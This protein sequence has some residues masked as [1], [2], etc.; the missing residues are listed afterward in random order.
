MRS[1]RKEIQKLLWFFIVYLIKNKAITKTK[2]K[3]I[4]N[5]L[6]NFI[7]KLLIE[8][9]KFSFVIQTASLEN[10]WNVFCFP[11]SK[12]LFFLCSNISSLVKF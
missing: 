7:K 8:I 12:N 3:I 5:S 4:N 2:N 10:T 6:L 11:T 1:Y 9:K